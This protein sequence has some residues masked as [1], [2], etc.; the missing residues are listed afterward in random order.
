MPEHCVAFGVHAGADAHEQASDTSAPLSSAPTP[1][2]APELPVE[3]T[4]LPPPELEP[5]SLP[6]PESLLEPLLEPP[7][8]LL[9]ELLSEPVPASTPASGAGAHLREETPFASIVTAP[10]RAKA[11]P[12]TVA[13]VFSVMLVSARIFPLN[14]VVVPSVAELPTC[15]KMLQS[16]APLRT[17]TD[18]LLAVVSVLPN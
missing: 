4:S 12:L 17:T 5:E 18:E 3:S 2:S 14:A 6:L 13:P 10:L 9:S 15:Q 16:W 11:R 7:L 8:E 1:A